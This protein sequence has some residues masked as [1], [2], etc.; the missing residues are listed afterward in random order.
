V[1]G[2]LQWISA[3]GMHVGAWSEDSTIPPH[4]LSS[5]SHAWVLLMLRRQ[6][7]PEHQHAASTPRHTHP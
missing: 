2:G 7:V 5:F 3:A 1:W 6:Q 4:V